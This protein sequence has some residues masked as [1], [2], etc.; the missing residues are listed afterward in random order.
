MTLSTT[1][2]TGDITPG[3]GEGLPLW[4]ASLPAVLAFDVGATTGWAMLSQASGF[5]SGT[6]DRGLRILDAPWTR[7][8]RARLIWATEQLEDE[9]LVIAIEDV[10]LGANVSVMAHLSRYVGAIIVLASQLDLSSVRVRPHS[11]QSVILGKVPRAQGKAL[12]VMRARAL[13]GPAIASEHEADA[14]LLAYFA[15]GALPRGLGP[16]RL[17]RAIAVDDELMRNGRLVRSEE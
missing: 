14:A 6:I 11:W 15:R 2:S 9:L 17:G 10:F 1:A 3:K 7:E 8:V 13:F 5:S 4:G 16:R 12:S